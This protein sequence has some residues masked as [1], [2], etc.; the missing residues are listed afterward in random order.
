MCSVLFYFILS[1]IFG[2]GVEQLEV[3]SYLPDQGLNLG[4]SGESAES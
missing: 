2:H 1:F 3:E 4:H